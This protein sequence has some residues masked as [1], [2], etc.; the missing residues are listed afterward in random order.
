[1]YLMDRNLFVHPVRFSQENPGN[2]SGTFSLERRK[3]RGIKTGKLAQ[4]EYFVF[5]TLLPRSVKGAQAKIVVY[6]PRNE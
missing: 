2:S 6:H 3:K 4:H 5:L 1:M